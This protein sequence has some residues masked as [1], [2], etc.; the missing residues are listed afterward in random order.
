VAGGA[1][2]PR[3]AGGGTPR[4][5]RT[6]SRRH[7]SQPRSHLSNTLERRLGRDNP[8]AHKGLLATGLAKLAGLL[9]GRG[10]VHEP[11]VAQEIQAGAALLG[12]PR[13]HEEVPD[14]IIQAVEIDRRRARAN[15]A[16]LE[17]G[18]ASSLRTSSRVLEQSGYQQEALA[19]A[20]ESEALRA[21]LGLPTQPH[22]AEEPRA[23]PGQHGDIWAPA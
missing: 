2:A 15:P 1:G 18:L 10:A 12:S 21:R 7:A 16:A 3:P 6:R 13:W 5:I 23:E 17:T 8:A 9:T 14:V 19:A 4:R 11:L 22:R 20:R